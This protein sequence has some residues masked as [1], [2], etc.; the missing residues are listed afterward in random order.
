MHQM[1]HPLRHFAV[2]CPG[3]FRTS[4]NASSKRYHELKRAESSES[5]WIPQPAARDLPETAETA[6]RRRPCSAVGRRQR[7]RPVRSRFDALGAHSGCYYGMMLYWRLRPVR[8]R[9]VRPHRGPRT[10][11]SRGLPTKRDMFLSYLICL[12]FPTH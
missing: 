8:P 4:A 6:P 12:L 3:C 1:Q 5:Y 9:P 10:T 7:T 2:R 11:A